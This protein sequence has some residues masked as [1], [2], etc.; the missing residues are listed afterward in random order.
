M[1]IT[2]ILTP[3]SIAFSYKANKISDIPDH[4]ID[5]FFL[6]DIIITFNSAYITDEFEIIYDRKSITKNYLTGWFFIDVF[7]IIPFDLL[8]SRDNEKYNKLARVARI[9]RMQ[10]NSQIRKTC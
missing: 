5:T 6:I 10:K 8:V 7:S 2:C 4:I 9:G 3:I 1:I